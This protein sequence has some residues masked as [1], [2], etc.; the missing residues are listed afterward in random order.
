MHLAVASGS[1]IGRSLGQSTITGTASSGTG[2]GFL[3]SH[4]VDSAV[5]SMSGTS[6]M[7]HFGCSACFGKYL[8]YSQYL[9]IVAIWNRH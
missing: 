6:L 1:G 3:Y 4:T 5:V 9:E 8:A 7:Y 2:L